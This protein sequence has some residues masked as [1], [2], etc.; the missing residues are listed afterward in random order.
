M[1]SAL[2][3]QLFG[4]LTVTPTCGTQGQVPG[5]NEMWNQLGLRSLSLSPEQG[6]PLPPGPQEKLLLIGEPS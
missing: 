1:P 6:S 5:R 3:D 2:N 4:A